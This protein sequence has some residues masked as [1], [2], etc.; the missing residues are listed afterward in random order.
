[1]N[2]KQIRYTASKASKGRSTPA[3]LVLPRYSETAAAVA[4]PTTKPVRAD[5]PRNASDRCPW[6]REIPRSAMFPVIA[7]VNTLP[8]VRNAMASLAPDASASNA[9]PRSPG[10]KRSGREGA[11]LRDLIKQTLHGRI[12]ELSSL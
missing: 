12:G 8:S 5:N 6:L 2:A 3:R 1:M 11:G 10:V 7:D 9:R 4:T